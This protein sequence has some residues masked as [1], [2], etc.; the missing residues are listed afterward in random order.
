LNGA[1]TCARAMRIPRETHQG[2]LSMDENQ[3]TTGDDD[4]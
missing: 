2:V 1:R 4:H 3:S